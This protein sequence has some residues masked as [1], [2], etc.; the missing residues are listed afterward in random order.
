MS[1]KIQIGKLAVYVLASVAIILALTAGAM[2][3]VP[4]GAEANVVSGLSSVPGVVPGVEQIYDGISRGDLVKALSYV[5]FGLI[6]AVVYLA[7]QLIKLTED[8]FSKLGALVA[9]LQ[10]RPCINTESA[11]LIPRIK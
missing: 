10:R 8:A 1:M 9:E 4:T 2:P 6:A 3:T 11:P 7:R 5:C